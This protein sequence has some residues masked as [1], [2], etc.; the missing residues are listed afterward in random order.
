MSIGV[1]CGSCNR[2]LLLGQL[3]QPSNGFRCHPAHPSY[4]TP[5][6][7]RPGFTGG[8]VA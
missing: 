8:W 5:K 2:E 6:T 3:V 4:L 1:R 7:E